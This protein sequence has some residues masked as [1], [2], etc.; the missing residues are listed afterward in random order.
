MTDYKPLD[1]GPIRE[2]HQSFRQWEILE[3]PYEAQT[4]VDDDIPSLLAEVVRLRR[5]VAMEHQRRGYRDLLVPLILV[6]MLCIDRHYHVCLRERLESIEEKQAGIE[7]RMVMT[8]D[9]VVA[10]H[11]RLVYLLS[12][13]PWLVSQLDRIQKKLDGTPTISTAAPTPPQGVT[14]AAGALTLSPEVHW[15]TLDEI[16]VKK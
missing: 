15:E 9:E 4:V 16:L 7:K 1:L 2:R 13:P 8:Y 3:L 6:L 10:S 14:L 12:V 5:E 11:T